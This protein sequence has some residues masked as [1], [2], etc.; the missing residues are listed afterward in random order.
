MTIGGCDPGKM[1]DYFA[2]ADITI[3]KGVATLK[4]CK[5]WLHKNYDEIVPVV[6]QR[7]FKANLRFLAVDST[8]QGQVIVDLFNARGVR[9]Q[10]I[11][12]GNKV[13]PIWVT[14]DSKVAKLSPIKH[15]MIQWYRWCAF[16]KR[17]K[18][19]EFGKKKLD[20][21]LM[22]QLKQ[23]ELLQGADPEHHENAKIQYGHPSGTHDDLAWAF[24]MALYVGRP[25]IEANGVHVVQVNTRQYFPS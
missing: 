10:D 20:D 1:N 24:L 5:Q 3:E 23:Q 6:A 17:V 14:E 15:E 9:T 2:Y 21:E 4:S 18:F 19:P 7:Y 8:G 12:Y 25:W 22:Q 16:Q 11:N 13:H